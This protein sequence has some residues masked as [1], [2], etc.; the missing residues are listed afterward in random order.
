M[1]SPDNVSHMI[2]LLT[3]REKGLDRGDLA[4][5]RR[6]DPTAIQCPV[7]WKLL[8]KYVPSVLDSSDP[9]VLSRWAAGMRAAV[10]LHGLHSSQ[11]GLGRALADAGYAEMRFARLLRAE[12]PTLWDELRSA[13]RFLAV[14]GK[15]ANAEHLVDLALVQGS[16]GESIRRKVAAD[17]YRNTNSFAD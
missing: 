5:L 6:L 1:T 16:R 4:D 2:S 17:Y 9:M 7:F 15:W 3:R 14:K 10:E 12:E 13:A 8:A 11:W